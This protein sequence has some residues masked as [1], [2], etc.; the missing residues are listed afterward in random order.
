MFASIFALSWFLTL[1]YVPEQMT[2]LR[3]NGTVIVQQIEG[4][5]IA[6][7]AEL[8]FTITAWDRLTIGGSI[9]N[10]QDVNT[11]VSYRPYQA[12]YKA[13][14]SLRVIDGV[15]LA[16]DHEC[17]HPVESDARLPD[18]VRLYGHSTCISLTLSGSTKNK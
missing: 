15:T 16:V 17:D 11:I 13:R 4:E 1:G 6:S 18:S 3:E 14:I 2:A 8:G 10:Y 7:V 12:D 5:R 9:E